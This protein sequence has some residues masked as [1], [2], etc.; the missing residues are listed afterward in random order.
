MSQKENI[1]I[2]LS[3]VCEKVNFQL[4]HAGIYN[5]LGKENITDHISKALKRA[6]EIIAQ[7]KLEQAN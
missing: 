4:E 1:Q 7:N 2:V 3:G 5:M 6:E